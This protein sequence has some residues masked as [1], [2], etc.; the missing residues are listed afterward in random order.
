LENK[1]E[2]QVE[3]QGGG[4]G[5]GGDLGAQVIS[6]LGNALAVADNKKESSSNTTHAAVSDG[7]WI[8]RDTENQKQDVA[9]LSS[10][11]DNAHSALN[12]IFD[13]EKEQNRVKEQQLLGEIGVQVIDIARTHAKANAIRD[14]KEQ[15]GRT[16]VT[17]DERKKAVAALKEQ[18]KNTVPDEKAITDYVFNDRVEQHLTESGFG[19]GGKYT[20]AMQAATAAVQGLMNGDL[21]AA[22]ANG[23]APFIA[24]EIKNLIPGE[25]T[26]SQLARVVAHG[27]ANAAL[28]LA[29]GDNAAAQATGAMTGEAVGILAEYIYKKQ[30][31]ELTEQEKENISAWATLASGLAGGLVGG[32]TQSA[33]NSAQAGKIV[34]E[35]NRLSTATEREIIQN[36]V[37]EGH[38]ESKL[39][40]AA[41]ALIKCYAQYP[42][43]SDE[44]NQNLALAKAGEQYK[45]EQ[46][47]LKNSKVTVEYTVDPLY[48]NKVGETISK[49]EGGFTYNQYDQIAD[50]KQVADAFKINYIA[51]QLGIDPGMVTLTKNGFE[52]AMIGIATSQ[53][54]QLTKPGELLGDNVKV[55][56]K[57]GDGKG[58]LGQID[59]ALPNGNGNLPVIREGKVTYEPLAKPNADE[60]RAGQK[61]ADQGYDVIYRATA[62][63]KGISGIRTSDLYV[64]GIGKID[65][66]T[67]KSTT[68]VDRILSSIEKKSGQAGGVIVQMDLSGKEMQGMAARLWGKPNAQNIKTLFFQDSKGTVHRFDRK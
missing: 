44:Y 42:V 31:G 33:A 19:T 58:V 45:D 24:N 2:Y 27:I 21:N 18:D 8:I 35:N 36:R 16:P 65:V 46:E 11:T 30:S 9:D 17:D 59:K 48:W 14:V 38:D 7:K 68:K 51:Q 6:N 41:C 4:L 22:L 47:L 26:D 62:S 23:A 3:H 67:P 20:R 1:A 52:V 28:A 64:S 49:E 50:G 43:G 53:A 40:A 61:F 63:D 15:F 13:K 66:Y 12:Q 55:N 57:H 5:T 39:N 34:V 37:N 60:L 56:V 29:K 54:G 32:D 25:G 10:D